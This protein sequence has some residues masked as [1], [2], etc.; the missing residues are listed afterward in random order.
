MAAPHYISKTLTAASDNA[1]SLS[2]TPAGAGNMLINGASATAGVA[3]LDTQRQVILTFAADETGHTFVVYGTS[4]GT[5][6]LQET[7]AGTT[8]G[9]VATTQ[10]FKTVTRISISAA[11][12]GAI[13]AGTNGIGATRWHAV[14][15]HVTPINIALAV[16][17][18]GTINYT[19]QYT[20]E[21]PGGTYPNPASVT[22][23]Y[24]TTPAG[25]LIAFPTAFNHQTL[26]AQTATLDGSLQ[27]P[28]A[29]LRLLVNSGTGTAQ[30][31]YQQAE[32]AGG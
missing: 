17:V 2:Q 20:V 6:L 10:N 1:I 5:D 21:D 4:E 16:N 22:Q 27:T 18:T 9:V 30:L 7:I 29:A 12:T 25:P 19:V 28:I 32:L 14:N 26:A 15:W 8:A 31:V 23:G 13:K 24:Q 3:T 11:A